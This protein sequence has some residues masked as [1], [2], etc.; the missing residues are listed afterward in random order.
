MDGGTEFIIITFIHI[1]SKHV[2]YMNP[3]RIVDYVLFN[4]W[5][6]RASRLLIIENGDQC[7]ILRNKTYN[8]EP[9][10]EFKIINGNGMYISGD[11]S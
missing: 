4:K 2:F 6:K 9:V 11:T 7:K 10:V 5:G 1:S 3:G 8:G